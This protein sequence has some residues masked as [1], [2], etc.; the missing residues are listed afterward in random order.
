MSQ[1]CR[2]GAANEPATAE[3]IAEMGR[4]VEEGIRA[5]GLGFSTSRT[6]LHK[7]I[8]GEPVPGTFAA[9]DELLGLAH[10][11]KRGGHGVFQ[12][13]AEH[14][15]MVAELQW[16][17]RI[18]RETGHAVT[19][20]VSQTDQAPQLWRELA[21]ELDGIGAEGL[22]VYGQ[23]AGRAIGIIMNLQATAHPFMNRVP[24]MEIMG[25]PWEQRLR[26]LADPAVR[27][28]IVNADPIDLWDF[29]DMVT[30]S[31]H[32]MYRMDKGADYEPRPEDSVASLAAA[33]GRRPEEV[34][35]ELLMGAD[36]K[37]EG[38]LYFPLFNYA[39]QSLD[40]L[41]SLHQH[42]QTLIGLGDAGAHCGAICDG[43]IPT[44]ML[45]F[46]TRDRS[47][48]PTLPLEHM[49]RRQTSATADLWGLQDR[50]RLLPGYRADLNLIDYDALDIGK[51]G[52]AFDLPA[53]G[54]RLV[55]HASG[56]RATFCRGVAISEEGVPTGLLPGRLIR[57]PSSPP[58]RSQRDV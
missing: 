33:S 18:A 6:M 52:L 36:G 29:A 41:H 16:M 39:E 57:G 22:P 40:L 46:W 20:P 23:V 45:S 13:A 28:R 32:K 19:F 47:R 56:Y 37:G 54:R 14:L 50:G 42:P 31:W 5:G 26:L 49:V 17:K 38:S 4:L 11:L 55:Q 12:V 27:E 34:A 21:A 2:L 10:A 24:Y 53:G 35:W 44:F 1:A 9:E 43:G 8:D 48:G 25:E 15:D 7:S 3:D 30:R 58:P 51:P